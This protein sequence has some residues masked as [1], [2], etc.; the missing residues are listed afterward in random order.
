VIRDRL[1]GAAAALLLFFAVAGA[2]VPVWAHDALV[3]R[4]VDANSTQIAA[5]KDPKARAKAQAAFT[6]LRS[7]LVNEPASPEPLP[8]FS[9]AARRELA[10]PGAYQLTAKIAPP[11]QRTWMQQAWDWIKDQFMKLMQSLYGK[12]HLGAGGAIAIG[13]ILIGAAVLALLFAVIRLLAEFQIDRR[14]AAAFQA[15]GAS[16]DSRELYERAHAAARSG[17]F[18]VASRLLFAAAIATL[19]LRGVVAEN[20]S[21]TVG[22][23]RRELR[24]RASTLIAPFDAVAAPFVASTYAERPVGT[25]DWDSAHAAYLKLAPERGAR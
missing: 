1:R 21:A 9:A 25:G 23:L 15:L 17:D 13:D 8:D 12:V 18:A 2:A 16:T 6:N 19:D 11:P 14:K 5:I 4:W 3:T 22:D 10:I 24:S 20:P 7:Q